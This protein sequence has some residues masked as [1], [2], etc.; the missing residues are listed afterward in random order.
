MI[1]TLLFMIAS[2]FFML[3][4]PFLS[5]LPPAATM[6]VIVAGVY[7]VILAAKNSPWLGPLITGWW[8]VALNVVLTVLALI[9]A[10]PANQLYTWNGLAIVL[11]GVLGSSGIHGMVTN[12]PSTP[13]AA[14]P[15]AEV[16]K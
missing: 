11:V 8:A 6:L 14:A 9:A 16:K 7:G 13:S 3:S 5:A 1:A 2:C 15:A 10:L 4:I 12:V